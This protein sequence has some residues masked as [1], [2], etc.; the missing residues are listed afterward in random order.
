M[1]KEVAQSNHKYCVK[2]VRKCQPLEQ[3]FITNAQKAMTVYLRDSS[4][5]YPERS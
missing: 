5:K 2:P 3:Y 4:I 1:Q